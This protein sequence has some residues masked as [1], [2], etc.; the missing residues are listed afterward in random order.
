MYNKKDTFLTHIYRYSRSML[1]TRTVLWLEKS[2]DLMLAVRG[3]DCEERGCM[4]VHK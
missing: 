3:S 1:A 2:R 4:C